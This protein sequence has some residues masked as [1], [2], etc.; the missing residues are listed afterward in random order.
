MDEHL[1]W[2]FFVTRWVILAVMAFGIGLLLDGATAVFKKDAEQ[3]KGRAVWVISFLLLTALH[4]GG[5]LY[6][7]QLPHWSMCIG[8]GL[9]TG[10][11]AI[12]LLKGI[13]DWLTIKIS[14][15]YVL[16]TSVAFAIVA[17]GT[18]LEQM[19]IDWIKKL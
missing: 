19:M 1:A 14:W 12:A 13:G 10:F 5:F 3:Y 11:C 4:I 16:L 18:S 6:R 9:I 2:Q 17:N 8:A 15:L 7:K